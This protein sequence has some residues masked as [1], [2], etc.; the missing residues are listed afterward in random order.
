MWPGMR[1]TGRQQA[2]DLWRTL[3]AANAAAYL[4]NGTLGDYRNKATPLDVADEFK[5]LF[6]AFAEFRKALAGISS[7]T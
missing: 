2:G 4:T 3:L 6:E 7:I 5:I 1:R